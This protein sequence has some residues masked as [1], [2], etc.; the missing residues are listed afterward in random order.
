MEWFN[1]C[2]TSIFIHWVLA[3]P[4]LGHPLYLVISF[5]Y[6]ASALVGFSIQTV[7]LA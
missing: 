7:I 2:D 4:N 3:K 5:P 1:N 6:K